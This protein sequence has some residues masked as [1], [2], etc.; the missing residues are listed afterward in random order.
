M[1]KM[2]DTVNQNSPE[3]VVENISFSIEANY[4]YYRLQLARRREEELEEFSY[5]SKVISLFI[6]TSLHNC[7]RLN[8]EAGNFE[9]VSAQHLTEIMNHCQ[10][11][12][13][14]FYDQD[15]EKIVTFL[16]NLLLLEI[17]GLES[18]ITPHY[19]LKLLGSLNYSDLEIEEQVVNQMWKVAYDYGSQLTDFPEIP[20]ETEI[21]EVI[22]TGDDDNKFA[23]VIMT[24]RDHPN[25][26]AQKV[27]ENYLSQLSDEQLD[28]AKR[29]G[30]N[31]YLLDGAESLYLHNSRFLQSL[32][33][34]NRHFD[35]NVIILDHHK[36][37]YLD[38]HGE[39][40]KGD[41]IVKK[42][43]T[44]LLELNRDILPPALVSY[45]HILSGE[46]SA[47]IAAGKFDSLPA[48][49]D[50]PHLLV[51]ESKTALDHDNMMQYIFY[52]YLKQLCIEMV[53]AKRGISNNLENIK[54][55]VTNRLSILGDVA[56][57]FG[58][59]DMFQGSVHS[60]VS[61]DTNMYG[62]LT[63]LRDTMCP[64]I[65]LTTVRPSDNRLA[66]MSIEK[67][68]EDDLQR[69]SAV[70]NSISLLWPNY[71][72]DTNAQAW[73]KPDPMEYQKYIE[74]KKAYSLTAKTPLLKLYET[75]KGMSYPTHLV[76]DFW[77]KLSERYRGQGYSLDTNSLLAELKNSD[78]V[79]HSEDGERKK[80][81]WT[82]FFQKNGL[83]YEHLKKK[84]SMELQMFNIYGVEVAY[85]PYGEN[86]PE[87][88]MN[89]VPENA[90]LIMNKGDNSSNVSGYTS[91]LT[92]KYT[93]KDIMD[94][95][96]KAIMQK[97]KDMLSCF[98][99]THKGIP[100]PYQHFEGNEKASGTR[101]AGVS[102][103]F[104]SIVPSLLSV[105]QDVS[106][107]VDIVN[108]SNAEL[109]ERC[110]KQIGSNSMSP[111]EVE[112]AKWKGIIGSLF[113]NPKH[114]RL[115]SV[116]SWIEI[117]EHSYDLLDQD[118]EFCERMYEL[119]SPPGITGL[120]ARV[121]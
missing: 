63:T 112:R 89:N 28:E 3:S 93:G 41:G 84:R 120:A 53:T 39:V 60:S 26:V 85:W 40:I 117:I 38:E 32:T 46:I 75:L 76:N 31:L 24:S 111:N 55:D 56:V 1:E 87:D 21:D 83:T 10:G 19:R 14:E 100:I 90:C 79:L 22:K 9:D 114:S 29:K 97:I 36:D 118:A 121:N 113:W 106:K 17:A 59:Q 4:R 54:K 74:T 7:V 71:T 116:K 48:I 20:K 27:V 44:K 52:K 78:T 64:N 107:T 30:I 80:A 11:L 82:K 96:R 104:A 105:I 92:M 73:L 94:D 108:M 119:E 33:F 109:W 2:L 15:D 103:D 49:F 5:T 37:C 67:R 51:I 102:P 95:R 91:C 13:H 23:C 58:W 8:L 43:K 25:D 42:D 62:L 77:T 47:W 12:L 101:D 50:R 99:S 18:Y 69:F 98:A 34:K 81:R 16:K 61:K 70:V 115:Q 45:Y 35:I 57:V 6:K 66:N 68:L 86:T 110:V 88:L 65:S 72:T